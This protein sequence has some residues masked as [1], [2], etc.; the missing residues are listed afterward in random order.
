MTGPIIGI[1]FDGTIVKHTYPDIGGP[2]PLAIETMKELQAKGC[3]LILYTMRSGSEL[4][5]AV[6]Y[7]K[8]NGIVMWGVNNNPEQAAWSISPK[9]YCNIYIDD[10]ALGCPLIEFISS[11]P[12]R[13]YV[14]WSEVR[15]MLMDRGL[16]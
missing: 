16:L 5:D 14:D 12:P 11:F 3:R 6:E 1:D 4:E 15:T 13:P 8:Q 10:A 9:V 2:C 7:L